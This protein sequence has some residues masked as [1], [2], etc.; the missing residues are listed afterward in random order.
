MT[1][2]A[3]QFVPAQVKKFY[4]DYQPYVDA[5]AKGATIGLAQFIILNGALYALKKP[6]HLT[7]PDNTTKIPNILS[8]IYPTSFLRLGMSL[9]MPLWSV[10]S[11]LSENKGS[12]NLFSNYPKRCEC[13][14]AKREIH[15]KFF[16]RKHLPQLALMLPKVSIVCGH[17][18]TYKSKM[19]SVVF[20]SLQALGIHLATFALSIR[21]LGLKN[22]LVFGAS[23][24]VVCGFSV[25]VRDIFDQFVFEKKAPI[26]VEIEN[27]V[28]KAKNRVKLPSPVTS[29]ADTISVIVALITL[30][31]AAALQKKYAKA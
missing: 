29:I 7:F 5:V 27:P 30:T 14:N 6:L 12:Q 23:T 4:G 28:T 8:Q 10:S 13:P 1:A 11:V 24:G 31:A 2:L 26:D 9:G 15:T 17:P 16:I 18:L 21:S 22:V 3:A 20:A 25:F 19:H